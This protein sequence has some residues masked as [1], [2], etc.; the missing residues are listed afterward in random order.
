MISLSVVENV[1]RSQIFR[2]G[3]VVATYG[4]GEL[5]ISAISSIS[6]AFEGMQR[7]N[8]HIVVV[9]NHPLSMDIGISQVVDAY[10]CLPHNPGFGAACNAGIK[11]LQGLAEFDFIMLLNPDAEISVDFAINLL[12]FLD[13]GYYLHDVPISPLLLFSDSY[14]GATV[15][16]ALNLQESD[17]LEIFDC[18]RALEIFDQYGSARIK[19][20]NNTFV[21]NASDY[22]VFPGEAADHTI[23]GRLNSFDLG[24]PISKF[25]VSTKKLAP[26]KKINNAGSYIIPPFTVGDCLYGDLFIANDWT[27][28]VEAALWCGAAVLLPK[29]YIDKVGLFD[30]R[31]FLYYEDADVSLRGTRLGHNP[32]VVPDLIVFHAHSAITGRNIGAR[33]KQIWRSRALFACKNYG[34]LFVILLLMK[35]IIQGTP[36]QLRRSSIKHFVRW[37]LPEIAETFFGI[38]IGLKPS[39]W[40]RRK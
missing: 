16:Q 20:N 29:Q 10:L 6:L 19:P 23:F 17:F 15:E 18:D 25:T 31:F 34:I 27:K 5:L 35:L 38:L 12:R 28:P 11:Y 30:E 4:A 37:I 13:E 33:Q 1:N 9:D 2:I 22:I 14:F 3:F 26:L 36:R 39:F 8:P 32:I 7:F 24:T 40:W 21:L